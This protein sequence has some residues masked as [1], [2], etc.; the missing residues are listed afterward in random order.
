MLLGL[1]TFLGRRLGDHSGAT[2]TP[3]FGVE[4]GWDFIYV[5]I[6]IYIY[7]YIY[8]CHYNYIYEINAI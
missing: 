5:H 1:G 8:T 2:G 3:G 7:I 6:C 4:E